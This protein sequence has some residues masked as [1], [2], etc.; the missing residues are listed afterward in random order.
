VE[1]DDIRGVRE[2]LRLTQTQ[3]A[4]LLG[5][6][7]LTI[8]KWERG[9]LVPSDHQVALMN[10]FGAAAERRANIGAV[11]AGLLVGAGVVAALYAILRAALR[12]D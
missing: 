7:P 1:P 10:S 6:H 9:V 8:S 11:V 4:Q 5:V 3:F 2:R 12:E